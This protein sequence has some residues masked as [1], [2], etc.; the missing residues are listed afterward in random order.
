[1]STCSKIEEKYH[2][3]SS[4]DVW[5]HIESSNWPWRSESPIQI[6]SYFAWCW[7]DFNPI[8]WSEISPPPRIEAGPHPVV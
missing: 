7:V 2:P 8:H 6:T 4:G 3:V 1:M 5:S